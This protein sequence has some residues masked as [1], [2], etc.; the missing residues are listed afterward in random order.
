MTLLHNLTN[1]FGSLLTTC[2]HDFGEI[3]VEIP[4]FT[5]SSDQM[6]ADK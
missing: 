6:D 3:A 5:S 2:E 1:W 4:G